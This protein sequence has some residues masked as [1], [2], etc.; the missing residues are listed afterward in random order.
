MKSIASHCPFRFVPICCA[1]TLVWPALGSAQIAAAEQVD[2]TNAA[3]QQVLRSWQQQTGQS[4]PFGTGIV[5]DPATGKPSTASSKGFEFHG[6]I[7]LGG[8]NNRVSNPSGNPALSSTREGSFGKLVFQGDARS[9]SAEQDVTYAQATLTSTDDRSFQSRYATQINNLQVGRTGIG[10]QIALGD[11]AANFSGLSTNQGLR[12]ALLAKDIGAFTLT[13]YAGIVAD[14]WEALTGR[15]TRDGQPSRTRN[16]R[17]VIGLKSEYKINP[18]GA[19]RASVYATVQNYRDRAGT[20]SAPPL[21][22]PPPVGTVI[23]PLTTLEGTVA[24]LGGQFNQGNLQ[25]TAELA[26]SRTQD[27]SAPQDSATDQAFVVDTLYRIGPVSLRAGHHNLGANYAALAQTN[28]P[29]VRETYAGADWQITPQLLWG[30]D[31]R[32]AV[33][34]AATLAALK[35]GT[36]LLPAS[37][38]SLDSLSNRLSYSLQ[39]IPGLALSLS[40]TRSKGLDALSNSNKIDT[41]Q[42]GASFANTTWNANFLVGFGQARGAAN[43]A[44]NSNNQNWQI[45]VGRNWRAADA[46]GWTLATQATIGQQTQK[47]I[48][49]SSS[50]MSNN[51]GLYL[52]ASY[53]QMGSLSAGWQQQNLSQPTA[54][55][56]DL[57]SNSFNVDWSREFGVHWIAKAYAKASKRNQGDLLLQFGERTVGLQGVYKW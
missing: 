37:Q 43:P 55:A 54:G 2:L 27:Q 35:G 29:G 9:I 28:A 40:D 12:G 42:L 46:G 18:Q 52:Q 5:V 20:G 38:S 30:I 3:N 17:D 53:P 22:L 56:P 19:F 26:S 48:A 7:E 31:A 23:A 49:T 41:T 21:L 4:I 51:L 14:S 10:Y 50:S 33:T 36:G 34:G 57:K 1:I 32:T 13:G 8:Y 24:S 11:V 15:D 44:S 6:Q 16:L 45:F 47:L 39:D 25:L